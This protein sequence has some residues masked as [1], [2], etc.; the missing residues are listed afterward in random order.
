[1]STIFPFESLS[2]ERRTLGLGVAVLLGI[3]F[4]FVL[5]R[6][7][8]GRARK[9]VGQFYGYDMTVLKVMFTGIV[10]AM[11]GATVLASA[12]VF[13]MSTVQFGYPTYL[14]PMIF[15]GLLLGAGFVVSGYCPGTSFVATASGKIDGLVTVLGVVA[16]GVLYA[17]LEPAMGAFPNSGKLGVF[18]LP[19]WLGLHPLVVVALVVVFAVGAFLAADRIEKAV[20][21]RRGS[22]AGDAIPAAT[23]AAPR[24]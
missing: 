10:T 6:A 16:G 1:M 3:A 24:S 17:E 22:T 21:A 15:G 18:T 20:N 14:W 2:D 12:G 23:P 19:K 13:D 8:F 5:E 4:G 11:I 9:L 7:G